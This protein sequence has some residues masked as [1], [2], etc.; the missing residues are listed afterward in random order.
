MPDLIFDQD[1]LSRSTSNSPPTH[2]TLTIE[3]FSMLTEN[4]VDTYESGEFDAGGYKWKLVVY[5]NGNTKKN[6]EDHISVYLKMA[7]A[8]SLQTG[9]EVSVDFRLFL[10]DQNKGIYLV[11]QDANMNKM[12]LHGAMLQVGFDRV[13][14]LKAFSV[15]SNGYLIDDTCVLGA[16][17]FVC[18]ERRAGKAECLSRINNAFMNKHC[19]KIE[20]FS[21][22]KSQCL[23]SEL[24]TAGGQKWKIDLYPKGTDDGKNTH[25]SVYLRLATP[26]KLSPGSQLLTEYTLRIVDQLDGKDKSRKSNHTWFSASNSCWGWPCFIKLGSFKM[27]DNGYLVKNTCLVEAEVTVHGIAK[28]LEPT[29]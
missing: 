2:Y 29:D 12:C 5:P 21:M 10:L 8:N 25:V 11:V 4:S 18:K 28:A 9:W 20:S 15:A 27:L 17:V 26:E 19:W 1:G 3:S 6:V 16:E 23:Q 7:E 24:F 22:L 13:I 14:P